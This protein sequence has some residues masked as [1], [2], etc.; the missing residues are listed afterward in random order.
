MPS[1]DYYEVLGI[2]KKA[3]ADEIR[4]A[5]RKLVRQYHPDVNKAP[6]AQKKFTEIQHAYD[7]LSDDK[8]RP[9]YDQ[10]GPAAF[11]TGSA[12]E[13][14]QR[15]GSR[16]SGPHYSWSNV[17][18]APRGDPGFDPDDLASVFES[19]F[20]GA[21]ASA[22]WPGDTNSKSKRRGGRRPRTSAE[23]TP[24]PVHRDLDVDF[25]TAARGGTQT[26]RLSEG[27]AARTIELTIPRAIET[28]TQ[29]RV[30]ADARG[31]SDIV[32]TIRV[33]PH[34]FFRRGEFEHTGKGLD[35]YLDLPLT[36]AEA[37]LGASVP[38]PTLDAQVEVTIPPGTPSGRKLRLRGKGL[39][40]DKG[41]DGDL[42]V[43]VRIVP[44]TGATL[45]ATEAS[46]LRDI[47]SRGGPCRPW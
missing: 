38:V 37:T 39:R 27:G 21:G 35:L 20:G 3:T 14:A 19:V 17:G 23:A 2:T 25:L 45:S 22:Q 40:G 32:F 6:D 26:L 7:V 34:K 11:E 47:A 1:R 13:A 43:V 9:L 16:G 31:G 41:Q 24:E 36:I 5:Y 29:M 4:S 8:K 33:Q 46:V 30:R 44:P 15:A 18:G 28:G 42:F 10:F 12:Q